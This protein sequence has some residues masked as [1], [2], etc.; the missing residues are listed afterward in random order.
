MDAD[1]KDEK[2]NWGSEAT[3][4][5]VR[6]Y[7]TFLKAS[8]SDKSGDGDISIDPVTDEDCGHIAKWHDPHSDNHHSKH[9]SK[10]NSHHGHDGWH[11]KHGWHDYETENWQTGHLD[12]VALTDMEWDMEGEHDSSHSSHKGGS[13]KGKHGH[14]HHHHHWHYHAK[15]LNAEA[16]WIPEQKTTTSIIIQGYYADESGNESPFCSSPYGCDTNY[17]LGVDWGKCE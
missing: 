5:K 10:Y 17:N 2:G 16:T 9:G 3:A 7:P 11:G 1:H 13:H 15:P 12:W 6:C 8:C 14:H 4:D